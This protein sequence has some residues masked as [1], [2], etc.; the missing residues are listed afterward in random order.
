VAGAGGGLEARVLEALRRAGRPLEFR[1]VLEA[2]GW[3][4][5]ARPVRRALASLV[6]GGLVERVPDY[7]SRRLRFRVAGG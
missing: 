3:E 1:E 6:R 4:G 5:D 7:G 2:L